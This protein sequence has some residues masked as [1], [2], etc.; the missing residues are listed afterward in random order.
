MNAMRVGTSSTSSG[1]PCWDP[2]GLKEQPSAGMTE[3]IFEWRQA[4]T[5][6]MNA[7]ERL[8][9]GVERDIGLLVDR[10]DR[11]EAPAKP[12]VA[13]SVRLSRR[14]RAHSWIEEST[15]AAPE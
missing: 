7:E 8:R 12:R 6:L 5:S 10:G 9:A 15:L 11:V 3:L 1:P 14:R 13:R 2:G 4:L